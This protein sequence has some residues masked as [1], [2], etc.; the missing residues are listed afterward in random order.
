V[1]SSHDYCLN[2]R[3]FVVS[4]TRTASCGSRLGVAAL[5]HDETMRTQEGSAEAA[6]AGGRAGAEQRDGGG[7]L[8]EARAL[9]AGTM[10]FLW[11]A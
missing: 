10:F 7:V 2:P 6:G 1:T 8:A 3:P 5:R 9:P 4:G 11:V